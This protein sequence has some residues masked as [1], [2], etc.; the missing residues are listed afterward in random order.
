M[1]FFDGCD[2]KDS[3]RMTKLKAKK[4]AVQKSVWVHNSHTKFSFLLMTV[5]Y[6]SLRIFV[7]L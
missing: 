3:D 2:L 5:V 4:T 6:E 1:I 7:G